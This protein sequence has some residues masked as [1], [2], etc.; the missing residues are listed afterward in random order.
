MLTFNVVLGYQ[1]LLFQN[2]FFCFSFFNLTDRPTQ[3]QETHLTLNEI[4]NLRSSAITIGL[5][6][7][8]SSKV[9]NFVFLGPTI[10][11]HLRGRGYG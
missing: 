7:K 10:F 6:L 2:L 8:K 1:G 5:D 4:L 11:Y 3:Y 9:C